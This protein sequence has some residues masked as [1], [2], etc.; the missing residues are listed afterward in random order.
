MSSFYIIISGVVLLSV[1]LGGIRIVIGPTHADRMLAVQFF[2]TSGTAIALLL[3]GALD[4]P[5]LRDLALVL[6]ALASVTTAAF[7]RDNFQRSSS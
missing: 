5:A 6:V 2:G 1:I 4:R 7:T 3:S